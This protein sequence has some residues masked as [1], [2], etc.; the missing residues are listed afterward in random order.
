MLSQ[1]EGGIEVGVPQG[2][3]LGSLLFL[4]YIN[5][6]P[7]A[8]Q[9]STISMYAGD[10][11]LCHQSTDT[12]QLNKAINNDLRKLDNWLHGNKL[13]LNVAKTHP[14]FL[15]LNKNVGCLKTNI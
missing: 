7:L 10:T 13:S 9:D 14:C 2:S 4:I 5:D 15:L 6:L 1:R 8:F 12:A 3:C 11:S